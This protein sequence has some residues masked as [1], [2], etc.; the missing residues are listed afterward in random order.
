ML[1]IPLQ[2]SKASAP[3]FVVIWQRHH[4]L[5]C[6]VGSGYQNGALME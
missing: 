5:A 4:Y 1:A 3:S 2:Y 6:N